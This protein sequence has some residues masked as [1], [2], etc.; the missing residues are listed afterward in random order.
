MIRSSRL[1]SK[2]ESDKTLHKRKRDTQ[3]DF[4]V[5]D[6]QDSGEGR[7]KP[8]NV[9]SEAR[10]NAL[11]QPLEMFE[12]SSAAIFQSKNTG[13]DVSDDLSK[14]K[15]EWR[16]DWKEGKSPTSPSNSEEDPHESRPR[17]PTNTSQDFNR[18][19]T[20]TDVEMAMDYPGDIPACN[21][22]RHEDTPSPSEAPDWRPLVSEQSIHA[23]LNPTTRRFRAL[24]RAYS[25]ALETVP[26]PTAADEFFEDDHSLTLSDDIICYVM[27]FLDTRSVCRCSLVCHRWH[28]VTQ[29]PRLWRSV[30]SY[31]T[32]L[33]DAFWSLMSKRAPKLQSLELFR[34]CFTEES[35]M[36]DALPWLSCITSLSVLDCRL[37]E[38]PLSSSRLLDLTNLTLM[39]NLRH[40]DL[41][42]TTFITEE[43]PT[44]HAW[45]SQSCPLLESL[46]LSC[47]NLGPAVARSISSPYH[48][49]RLVIA[50]VSSIMSDALPT[51][52]KC[53]PR[54][55]ELTIV[56]TGCDALVDT[57]AISSLTSLHKLHLRFWT[58]IDDVR[59]IRALPYLEHIAVDSIFDW[60]PA[61]FKHL[62][63]LTSLSMESAPVSDRCDFGATFAAVL[64]TM[65][66]L[67]KLSLQC[68][69]AS[70]ASFFPRLMALEY[71]KVRL[72]P[73]LSC[74]TGASLGLLARGLKECPRFR[75]FTVKIWSKVDRE[76]DSLLLFV[77]EL[78][79]L[80]SMLRTMKVILFRNGNDWRGARSL[81]A[82]PWVLPKTIIRVKDVGWSKDEQ[83][84]NA[85]PFLLS[86]VT[87]YSPRPVGPQCV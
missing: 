81:C 80:A 26:T 23:P 64:H 38:R 35:P 60:R 55:T 30:T 21:L 71:L 67:R 73:A 41:S 37:F 46:T 65:P 69:T 74:G 77:Q 42:C 36:D 56:S 8:S 62:S 4:G 32:L 59:F 39:P 34:C 86:Q 70:F 45:I 66:F 20:Y 57:E 24:E 43:D 16:L 11:L 82:L 28:L 76:H 61:D 17:T 1:K 18:C 84:S 72:D 58:Q 50:G 49:T 14:E 29:E 51:L 13:V 87:T 12:R 47:E 52:C 53:A 85:S 78:H 79:G 25:Y 9:W 63:Y 75:R 3:G 83:A 6:Q 7:G 54:L 68:I 5:I 44:T 2:T 22:F 33:D 48:L 15:K 27:S 19:L 31:R 10:S 40:L